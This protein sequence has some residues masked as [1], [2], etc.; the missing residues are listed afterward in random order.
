MRSIELFLWCSSHWMFNCTAEVR[1]QTITFR[2]VRQSSTATAPCSPNE[3]DFGND[4]GSGCIVE[5]PQLPLKKRRTCLLVIVECTKLYVIEVIFAG[6]SE[7]W[8]LKSQCETINPKHK[9][10]NRSYSYIHDI[11]PKSPRVPCCRPSRK[12]KKRV[13]CLFVEEDNEMTTTNSMSGEWFFKTAN[14]LI[15]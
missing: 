5:L 7:E 11:W 3:L 2:K 15:S 6:Y 1:A 4:H 13:K 12:K 10:K 9:L 8:K 14:M